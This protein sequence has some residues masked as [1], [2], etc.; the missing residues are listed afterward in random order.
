MSRFA[1]GV[2][3]AVEVAVAAVGLV[4]LAPVFLA[5]AALIRVRMGAP[6][7]FRQQRLGRGAQPF[8]LLKFRSMHFPRP[9]QEGPEFD[10]LRLGRLGRVLRA[11]SLDELPSLVNLLRGEIG[12]VGPRPLPVHYL[13][14]FSEQQRRRFE[15]KPGITG[16]AQVAG[17][18]AVDWPERLAL[19]VEYVDTRSL[20]LDLRLLLRTI[21]MV[22]RRTGVDHAEGVTM[23]ELP[24]Q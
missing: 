9:G 2:R 15:V 18:N 22:L 23:K 12:L 16:L 6:V 8:H 14:R 4:V 17:R 21:P 20:W 10:H 7:L 13:P 11:S 3:R 1:D 19:D 24:P 5:V